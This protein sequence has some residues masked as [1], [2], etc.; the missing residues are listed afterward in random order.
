MAS[1]VIIV[2]AGASLE[3]DRSGTMPTGS[4]LSAQIEQLLGSELQTLK[5][6]REL[7]PIG[8]ALGFGIQRDQA[9]IDAMERIRDGIVSK[10]SIDDFI[11]EWREIP[12]LLR[13][14]KLCIAHIIINAERLSLL[15]HLEGRG[16][17]PPGYL[18]N[19]TEP[20]RELRESW[21]GIVSRHLRPDVRRRDVSEVF[22]DVAF[23][24]FNYDRCVEYFLY[25][26]FTHTYKLSHDQAALVINKI[27]ILHVYGSLGSLPQ[28]VQAPASNPVPF[29]A[30]DWY[31]RQAGPSIKTYTEEME[32]GHTELIRQAMSKATK[33]IFLGYSYHSHNMSIL[34][35][36]GCP[37]QA[38][39]WGTIFGM[40]DPDL[41]KLN[42]YF[43]LTEHN[44]CFINAVC[45]DFLN[46]TSG[47]IFG[48]E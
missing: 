30:C 17:A 39:V 43:A 21:L 6:T 37:K 29:G 32:S 26:S 5:H 15:G 3:M 24:V 28:L 23:I 48:S 27:P 45:K 1:T 9:V 13:V 40:N 10:D 8:K 34:F 31:T 12:E 33:I 18:P 16:S 20:L 44:P 46:S 25:R 7:G 35:P 4:A 14:A 38:R 2:G 47:A 41:S 42:S 11:G 22:A 19:I 36:E